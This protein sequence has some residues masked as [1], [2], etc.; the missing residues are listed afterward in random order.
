MAYLSVIVCTHNPRRDY[1]QRVLEALNNQTLTKDRWELLIIDN[2]SAESLA[3]A[4]DL[5]WHASARHIR[6]DVVGLT[7][8]RLRGIA[9]SQG[10]LLVF[11]DDDNVL[12]EDFLERAVDISG[13]YAHIGAFG[14]GRLEPEFEVQPPDEIRS[15]LP[16]LALRSVRSAQWS[17]NPRDHQV[18]PWGAGLCVRRRV[19]SHYPDFVDRLGISGV[20]GRKGWELFS[21]DDD[22]F[23]WVA[24]SLRLGFGIFPE[25]KATHLIAAHRLRQE[26]VIKLIRGH[27]FSHG[28]LRYMLTGAEPKRIHWSQWLLALLHGVRKGRFSMRCHWARSRGQHD[29]AQFLAVQGRD[30]TVTNNNANGPFAIRAQAVRGE[31]G[32]QF[33]GLDRSVG[34]ARQRR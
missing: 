19:A 28:A 2:G 9:E 15:S 18:I 17:N 31:R 14:S 26:Y 23:S 27:A 1:L 3:D 34:A 8:A 22:V 30:R 10:E 4:W 11:V 21:G 25:L 32:R 20:L 6:E 5:S 16:M 24:T 29:A 33:A 13:K 12:A 7:A